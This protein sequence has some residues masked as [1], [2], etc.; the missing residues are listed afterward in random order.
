[1]DVLKLEHV[2]HSFGEVQALD[3]LS[4]SIAAG[5]LVCLLGPSGCGKTTA[6]RIAAG[7]EHLQHGRV[8]LDG[9]PVAD[10]KRDMPPEQRS[11]GLVFQD[12]ALFPHLTVLENVTFGLRK[13]PARKREARAREVL[14]QVGMAD[15]AEAHPHMLSGGQQQRVAVARA[16]APRPRVM[17]LD[18]PFSGLDAALRNQIRDETLHVLK[19]SGAAT[20]MVTHDPEEA[21]FMAD[22]VILM[23]AGR[24]VQAGPPAQLYAAPTDKFVASFFGD[25]NRL[26][27][28]VRGGRAATPFG[29]VDAQG[30]ADGTEV[31]ILIRP[32]ALRLQPLGGE[33]KPGHHSARVMAAR[34][35]GRSS[36]VHLSLDNWGSTDDGG[37]DVH[38]HARI[39]GRFLPPEN[40]LLEIHLDRSQTFVFPAEGAR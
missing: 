13:Q 26:R 25:I 40:E 34:L 8:L 15:Y 9:R 37:Q 7:L 2:S 39:P 1:M 11:V 5:E 12:Y 31:E 21:M 36:M 23:R 19:E 32:E 6:L 17:L 4:L 14:D 10:A 29:D 30:L 24:I 28:I 20:L 18:E 16:L 22:R 3:D 35:L 38:L 27:G 33:A